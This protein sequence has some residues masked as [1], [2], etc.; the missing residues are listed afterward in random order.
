MQ[1]MDDAGRDE[2]RMLRARAY[3]PSADI[4]DDGAAL[5]RLREL[6]ARERSARTVVSA[7][8]ADHAELPPRPPVPPPP[9]PRLPPVLPAGPTNA[10]PVVPRTPRRRWL[11][12]RGLA[13]LWVVS[14]VA[15]AAIAAGTAWA[16]SW[17]ARV[18]VHTDARQIATLD[19][20][21]D[22]KFPEGMFGDG[23]P[24][25][26]GYEFRGLTIMRAP[27]G[28]Q[29]GGDAPCLIAVASA[30]IEETGGIDGPLFSGCGAG[31]F[32]ATVQFL[33]VPESP[34]EL[35]STL[36][37]GSAIQFVLD[38]DRVG[39]FSDAH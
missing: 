1:V 11:L 14:L 27:R 5:R 33:V 38:G 24:D 19:P 2:L 31:G 18:V 13:V 12:S 7:A 39:V 3:G 10:G 8:G 21:G 26:I 9:A 35:R 34:A 6:E 15:V 30:G 32:P 4:E 17:V 22:V 28:L 29:P 37:V 16:S 20:D 25:V 36:P 23:R